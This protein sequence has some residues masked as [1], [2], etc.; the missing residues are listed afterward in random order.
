VN[1]ALDGSLTD[2]VALDRRRIKALNVEVV[3]SETPAV[4]EGHAFTT[5]AIPRTSI[6]HVLPQSWVEVGIKDGLGCDANAY[7][8]HHFT[9][10][11]L[12]GKPQPDQHWHEHATCFRLGDRGLVV[13]SSCGHGGIINT[14]KRARRSTGSKR[15]MRCSAASIWRRRRTTICAKS[16]RS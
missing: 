2:P 12:A 3:L 11:E 14:L 5:G 7:M 10:D 15:S 6:E 16:W 1:R 8:N 9:A 13:I 4:I